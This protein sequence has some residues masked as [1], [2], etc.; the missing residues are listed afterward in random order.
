MGICVYAPRIYTPFCAKK[1]FRFALWKVTMATSSAL[2]KWSKGK[3]WWAYFIPVTSGTETKMVFLAMKICFLIPTGFEPK[4]LGMLPPPCH[5]VEPGTAASTYGK[6]WEV[7]RNRVPMRSL[8]PKSCYTLSDP[9]PVPL[10]NSLWIKN[11]FLA[12][13]ILNCLLKHSV[14]R[15]LRKQI[16]AWPTV[17]IILM[18]KKH[19]VY[20]SLTQKRAT[21]FISNRAAYLVPQCPPQQSVRRWD[22]V[23][24]SIL[25]TVSVRIAFQI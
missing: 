8:G 9:S 23:N 1:H 14:K 2:G 15:I 16:P 21:G 7:K 11:S 22:A 24:L 17:L 10:P 5:C 3:G 4:M 12:Q 13:A 6:S 25:R 18:T 20:T 19:Y